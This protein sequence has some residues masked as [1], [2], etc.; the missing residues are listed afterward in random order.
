MIAMSAVGALIATAGTAAACGP[1]GQAQSG[2]VHQAPIFPETQAA[3]ASQVPI[4]PAM[5][6]G[7]AEDDSQRGIVGLWHV[8]YTDSTGAPFYEAYDMWHADGNEWETS[9]GDPRL[10]NY[11]LGVWKAGGRRT[12][13]LSHFAWIYNSDGTPAGYFTLSETDTVSRTGDS[14]TGIFD[15]KQYDVNG[16]FQL[17]VTGTQAATRF[18][19]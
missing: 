4:S 17:E 9:F 8:Y 18:K 14:Y 6:G 10:G 3:V 15:Y 19:L 1:N 16:N 7:P 2:V 12:V 11:C 5:A 13:Q